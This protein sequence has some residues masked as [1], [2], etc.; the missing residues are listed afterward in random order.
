[1]LE[2][3]NAANAKAQAELDDIKKT[4]DITE[5]LTLEAIQSDPNN[6]ALGPLAAIL[7]DGDRG[8]HGRLRHGREDNALRVTCQVC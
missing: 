6:A 7:G 8:G 2:A 4:G 5:I 3:V 1:M